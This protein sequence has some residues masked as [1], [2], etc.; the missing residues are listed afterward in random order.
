[1]LDPE[2]EQATS[3]I[4]PIIIEEWSPWPLR[5]RPLSVSSSAAKCGLDWLAQVGFNAVTITIGITYLYI[6]RISCA[7]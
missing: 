2:L 6:K 1:M 4:F 3:L 7:S 5:D